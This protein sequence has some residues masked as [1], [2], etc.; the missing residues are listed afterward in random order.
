MEKLQSKL[1]RTVRKYWKYWKGSWKESGQG[2]GRERQRMELLSGNTSA[3]IHE[4][5]GT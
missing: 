1:F 2:K 4:C 3:R 5:Y